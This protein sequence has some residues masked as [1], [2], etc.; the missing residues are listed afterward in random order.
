VKS[1][2]VALSLFALAV[3]IVAAIAA[4]THGS[5]SAAASRPR[6]AL[7]PVTRVVLVM[8]E[9]HSRS[10]ALAGMPYLRSL[11]TTYAQVPHYNAIT[12]PSLPNYIAL[13]SGSISGFDGK[14][15]SPSGGCQTSRDNIFHQTPAWAVW[16]ESMP[17]PCDHSNAGAYAPRHTMAPYY[18]DLNSTCP[19]N[20][21]PLT[22]N[23]IPGLLHKRF[24]EVTPNLNHDAHD[25]S[26][27]AAD[28]WLK[29]FM[30]TILA[31]PRFKD[32]ST[33]VE[34]TFDEGSHGDNTVALALINPRLHG[35]SISGSY[36][37]YSLLRLNEELMGNHPVG[38]AA[39]AADLRPKLG[40]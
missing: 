36:N 25:G 12:H 9:N 18:T 31:R 37:H 21:V 23:P 17:K 15:C 19:Q 27:A 16:A 24:I 5:A 2:T 10:A 33:L 26:L 30:T 39:D 7:A 6:A 22:L 35:Q 14:D 38:H 13:S 34:V 40:L 11:A 1:R 29:Q 28:R 4:G 8:E 3:A 20:D 32:G